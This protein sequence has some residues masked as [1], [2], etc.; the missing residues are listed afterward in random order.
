VVLLIA[1]VKGDFRVSLQARPG[2][3]NVW[4]ILLREIFPHV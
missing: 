3:Y 4:G 2:Q 1:S